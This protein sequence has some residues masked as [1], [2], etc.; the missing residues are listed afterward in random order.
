VKAAFIHAEVNSDEDFVP[1]AFM[2]ALFES[3]KT[4]KEDQWKFFLD[5]QEGEEFREEV[6]YY[7]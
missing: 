6:K 7:S 4:T 5:G 3:C 2:K 1:D